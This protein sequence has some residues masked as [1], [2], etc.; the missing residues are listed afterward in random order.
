MA[1]KGMERTS[2]DGRMLYAVV[3]APNGELWAREYRWS[4]T[5]KMYTLSSSHL[6]YNDEQARRW[7]DNHEEA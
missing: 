7:F 6:V 2:S 1:Y 5:L 4:K 3:E